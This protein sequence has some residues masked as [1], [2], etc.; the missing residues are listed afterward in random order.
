MHED[1]FHR[2]MKLRK[3]VI[4]LNPC[5]WM[6]V[7]ETMRILRRLRE[8]VTGHSNLDTCIAAFTL[9]PKRRLWYYGMR[10]TQSVLLRLIQAVLEFLFDTDMIKGVGLAFSDAAGTIYLVDELWFVIVD[11]DNLCMRLRLDE[12]VV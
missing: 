3:C 6:C 5:G 1:L 4:D 2:E 8:S 7:S 9:F 12:V 10:C 11:S